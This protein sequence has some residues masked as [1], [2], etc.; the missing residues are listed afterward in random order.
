MAACRSDAIDERTDV[1]LLGALL[2]KLV[3]GSCRNGGRELF[4]MLVSAYAAEP[5]DYGEQVPTEL[6]Q[7][8]NKACAKSRRVSG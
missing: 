7:I 6:A 8:C 5:H 1:Y 2:H 3:V 4:D